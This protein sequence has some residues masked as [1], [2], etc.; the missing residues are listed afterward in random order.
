MD[1]PE[2]ELENAI[3]IRRT[4]M[5]NSACSLRG[6]HVTVEKKY[7]FYDTSIL[8]KAEI[9]NIPCVENESFSAETPAKRSL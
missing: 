3:F 8:H 7:S 2:S 9:F 5:R 1:Y 6:N 4:C